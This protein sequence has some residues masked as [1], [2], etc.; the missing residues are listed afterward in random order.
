M[1]TELTVLPGGRRDPV[2]ASYAEAIQVGGVLAQSGFFKDAR[3]E[4]QAAA[5]VIA[6]MELG[7]GPM[8][9]LT[10]IH[11][12][13]DKITLSANLIAALIQRSGRYTYR[14][15]VMEPEAVEI[16]FFEGGKAIGRS[17]FTKA[18]ATAANLWGKAGPWKQHP[19]N[20]LF[21]RAMSNGAK[22]YCPD[23]FAGPVYTP[24][25]LGAQVDGETGEV[26]DLPAAPPAPAEVDGTA[27]L[28]RSRV[29]ELR[30][31]MTGEAFAAVMQAAGISRDDLADDDTYARARDAMAAAA[32][33]TDDTVS[34][35][36]VTQPQMAALHAAGAEHGLD[37]DALHQLA[38]DLFGVESMR[39][40][41][42]DGMD[43]MLEAIEQAGEA[44]A[45]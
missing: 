5:K 20:M 40:I 18:D 43:Q 42:R 38:H 44:G 3:S 23:V 19:R 15:T 33:E 29:R 45:A 41:P 11:L 6:G 16:A 10:G 4:A 34:R 26:I 30:G 36:T 9:S 17:A 28:I 24:D 13:Q 7:L 12:V 35:E 37:H 32:A 22:W 1:S 14:V 31:G 2:P 27:E 8:A 21:A 25:E 39:D